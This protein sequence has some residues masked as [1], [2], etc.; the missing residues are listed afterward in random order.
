MKD[1]NDDVVTSETVCDLDLTQDNT[2]VKKDSGLYVKNSVEYNERIP[3]SVYLFNK[4]ILYWL[5][6]S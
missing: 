4:C 5:I 1:V 6:D 3:R 2:W